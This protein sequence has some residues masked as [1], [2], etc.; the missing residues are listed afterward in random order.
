MCQVLARRMQRMKRAAA[1]HGAKPCTG[2]TMPPPPRPA[3]A[4]THGHEALPT[5]HHAAP[6]AAPLATQ[7]SASSPRPPKPQEPTLHIPHDVLS[8]M[9]RGDG[10]LLGTP[11]TAPTATALCWRLQP[12]VMHDACACAWRPM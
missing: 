10:T 5:P 6:R 3:A 2:L 7:H 8:R 12:R 1:E 4:A 11:P 9:K